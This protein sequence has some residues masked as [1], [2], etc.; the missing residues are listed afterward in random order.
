MYLRTGEGPPNRD[1]SLGYEKEK[2]YKQA[3]GQQQQHEIEANLGY[4]VQHQPE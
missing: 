4:P 1:K 2:K 3:E